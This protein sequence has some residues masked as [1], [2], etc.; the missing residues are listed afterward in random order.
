MCLANA[1]RRLT[2]PVPV[3]LNRLDAPLWVF[4]LGMRG[5]LMIDFGRLPPEERAGMKFLNE[6]S[7]IVPVL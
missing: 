2:L 3:F 1:W 6:Y 4:N 5:L 7:R